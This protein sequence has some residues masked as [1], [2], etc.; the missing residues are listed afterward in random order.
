MDRKQLLALYRV[1]LTARQI[2]QLELE[3]NNRGEAFFHVSGAGH[4]GTAVLASLLQADDWLLCHYRDKALLLARG[5]TP[6]TFFDGL[7]CKQASPTRGRQ[8]CA[9][10]FADRELKILSAPVPVGNA[11]LQT[12]GLAT[13][14][15]HHDSRPLVLHS[16]GDGG[17]QEGEFLEACAEAVRLQLPLLFLIQDNQLAISTK[18]HGQTFYS[19]PDGDAATFYGLP[20]HRI[21]GRN[22]VTAWPRLREVVATIRQTRAPEIVVFDVDRLSSHTHADDELTYRDPDEIRRVA[23][24]GDPLANLEHHLRGAGCSAA[25]L[26]RI[27][28]DVAREVAEAEAAAYAGPEPVPTLTAKPPIQVELTHPSRERHGIATGTGLTMREALC[29]VLR[30]RLRQDADVYLLGQDIEDPKGDVFGVTR[31]LSTEFPG[32][33]RNAPLS[34]STIVGSSIG[35]ALGGRRPVAFIQFADFLP[36]AYN[37]LANELGSLYWRN[38]G[39]FQAPVI[40]MVAC[41]G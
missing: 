12:V 39:Q 2:D 22:V 17:T 32:R 26:E 5:V 23:R 24:T 3:L 10:A 38:D 16:L 13:V 34:E 36:L 14:I 30:H 21:D 29:N 19:R 40:V 11:A 20:I 9:H 1:M 4:E 18:T 37:Q 41:G 8:M 6:R 31:G 27:R 33:V 35:Q 28:D 15:K 25:E 7:F